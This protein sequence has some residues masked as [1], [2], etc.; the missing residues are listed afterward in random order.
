MINV[1]GRTEKGLFRENN[2]DY[3]LSTFNQHGDFVAIVCDGV[4]GNLAGDIASQKTAEFI[5]DIFLKLENNFFQEISD[6]TKFLDLLVSKTNQYI[7]NISLSNTSYYNMATTLNI[8]LIASNGLK[9]IANVGDSRIYS[10]DSLFLSQISYDH[11]LENYYKGRNYQTNLLKRNV[12]TSAIGID[13]EL[14]VQILDVTKYQNFLLC[15]DGLYNFISFEKLKKILLSN[16]NYIEKLD[17][18]FQLVME[19]STDNIT[20]I[21]VEIEDVNK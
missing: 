8:L 10:Y 21:V 20:G 2:Q 19:E 9:A 11:N 18:L 5:Q 12:V 6:L 1:Y 14:Q 17:L 4:G 7:K 3:F 16:F 15:S 13:G